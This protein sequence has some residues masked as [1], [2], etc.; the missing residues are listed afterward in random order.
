MTKTRLGLGRSFPGRGAL[1]GWRRACA[2]RYGKSG[3]AVT[4]T[5]TPRRRYDPMS[6]RRLCIVCHRPCDGTRCP[7][8]TLQKRSGSY[9]RSARK[10]VENA[11]RC[12][13]CGQGPRPGDPF[14]ADHLIPRAYGGPDDPT[15]LAPAHRSCNGRRGNRLRIEGAWG[16]GAGGN[17]EPLSTLATPVPET[18]DPSWQ[19]LRP[20]R[21]TLPDARRVRSTNS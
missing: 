4:A 5:A 21:V 17:R 20:R 7:E 8:H 18:H 15:N 3:C 19:R 1:A 11:T 10:I 13:L 14:V 9:T 12:H 2:C 6:P 16:S